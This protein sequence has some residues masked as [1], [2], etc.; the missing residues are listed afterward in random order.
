MITVVIISVLVSC[1]LPTLAL[2][3]EGTRSIGCINHLRQIGLG[4]MAYAADNRGLLMPNKIE[5]ETYDASKSPTSAGSWNSPWTEL[6]WDYLP[7][8]G[9]GSK[10]REVYT[11]PQARLVKAI[12]QWPSTYG[13]NGSVH[14][15]CS[16]RVGG[17]P[18]PGYGDHSQ[19]SYIRA[20]QI[21]RPSEI[22]SFMDSSQ[23]PNAGTTTD[24]LAYS[25]SGVSELKLSNQ[26]RAD[27]QADGEHGV[28]TWYVNANSEMNA[29]FP[30]WR[31]QR[32]TRGG[33]VFVDGHAAAV[34]RTETLIRNFSTAY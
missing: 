19:W 10:Q 5:W 33:M 13:A 3:R 9:N 14:P 27:L 11:C 21:P 22:I 32:N 29:Y 31:H 30:R 18:A 12:T 34:G 15:F 8:N 17:N 26:W 20:M 24:L 4:D 25:T 6:M 23:G 1:L 7:K 28:N 2:V 16:D